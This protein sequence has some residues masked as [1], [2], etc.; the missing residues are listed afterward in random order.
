MADNMPSSLRTPHTT[1]APDRKTERGRNETKPN[2]TRVKEEGREEWEVTE[3]TISA[4]AAVCGPKGDEQQ[5]ID[6][7][8]EPQ[9]RWSSS[10][11]QALEEICPK[12]WTEAPWRLTST[13]VPLTP[14]PVWTF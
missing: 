3:S 13:S 2:Q 12:P 8:Q 11:G 10:L 14:P 5:K 4:K 6:R 7:D 1:R 9:G